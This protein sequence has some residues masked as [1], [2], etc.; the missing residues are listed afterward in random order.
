MAATVEEMKN[1]LEEAQR[2]EETRA[3]NAQA[4][5]A[6][7]QTERENAESQR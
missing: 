1:S 4:Q 3:Q 5:M 2:N 6:L 7:R